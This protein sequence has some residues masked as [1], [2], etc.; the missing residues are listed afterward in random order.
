MMYM[1]IFLLKP[2]LYKESQLNGL[3]NVH[4]HVYHVHITCIITITCT[5][6]CTCT[7]TII[8][9][10][11]IIQNC[12]NYFHSYGSP[13]GPTLQRGLVPLLN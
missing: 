12:Y 1:Y 10:Y 3:F 7:Y 5:C 9:V 4:I 6:I 2:P 13:I 8:H 11:V